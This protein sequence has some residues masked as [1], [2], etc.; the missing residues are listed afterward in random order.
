MAANIKTSGPDSPGLRT[1]RRLRI[2]GVVL[3]VL[4][5][6]GAEMVYFCGSRPGDL[7]DDPSLIGYDKV[8]TRQAA[9]LYGQQ[10][11][12][13]QEWANALKR[14]GTQAVIVGVAAVMA[15]GACFYFARLLERN[16]Q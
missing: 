10:G 12:L 2:I 3:V 8:V 14:P 13:L 16:A 11:V 7:P 4:G 5:I 15:A 6:A 1:V 9:T